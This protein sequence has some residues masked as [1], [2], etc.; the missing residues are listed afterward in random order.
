M[1]RYD[2]IGDIHG[3]ASE[4]KTLF[5]ELGYEPDGSSVYRH[6]DRT[7]GELRPAHQRR[8]RTNTV[9]LTAVTQGG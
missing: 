3:C 2:I 6:P 9:G 1:T 8:R 4:L 7:A 5:G